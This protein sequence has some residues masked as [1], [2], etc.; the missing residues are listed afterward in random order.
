MGAS[1]RADVAPRLVWGEDAGAI[2]YYQLSAGSF[3]PLLV[4]RFTW[5]GTAFTLGPVVEVAPSGA[6]PYGPAIAHVTGDVYFLAWAEGTSPDLFLR[7]R[8]VD[9]AP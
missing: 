9:L 3:G 4:Q 5:D 7:G 1:R 8:Y 2:A 6:A